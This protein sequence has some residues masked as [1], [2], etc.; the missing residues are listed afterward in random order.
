M[1]DSQDGQTNVEKASQEEH[2]EMEVEK[3]KKRKSATASPKK[4]AAKQPKMQLPFELV[5]CGGGGACGFNSIAVGMA[6]NHGKDR[7]KTLQE[8]ASL[9]AQLRVLL[10]T[11]FES[12]GWFATHFVPNQGTNAMCGGPVPATWSEY[13]A[14]VLRPAFWCDALC[15]LGLARRLQQKIVVVMYNSATAQWEKRA[16]LGNSENTIAIVLALQ[17]NHY[18]LV[19]P[20][21]D[22]PLPE[23]WIS[24]AEDLDLG[25]IDITGG[26]A[27]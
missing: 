2:N 24:A 20:T 12:K 16:V 3:D 5:E 9:G 11:Y 18:Q 17:D 23:E 26:M 19:L 14:A 6:L 10:N 27:R 8:A 4:H 22:H 25:H 15:L 21:K 1:L 7:K 13:V